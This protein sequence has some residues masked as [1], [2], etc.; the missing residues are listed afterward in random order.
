MTQDEINTALKGCQAYIGDILDYKN[1]TE[2]EITLD[3]DFTLAHLEA[4]V[5][6]MKNYKAEQG[7]S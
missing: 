2:P 3:G 6:E 4:L 1:G 7:A 5:E